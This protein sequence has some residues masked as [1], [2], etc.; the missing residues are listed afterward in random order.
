MGDPHLVHNIRA[1]REP[2]RCDVLICNRIPRSLKSRRPWSGKVSAH[3]MEKTTEQGR[4]Q[5]PMEWMEWIDAGYMRIYFWILGTVKENENKDG[6]NMYIVYLYLYIH[7]IDL[8][9]HLFHIIQHGNRL[10]CIE[11]LCAYTNIWFLQVSHCLLAT[12]CHLLRLHR[13]A[14]PIH[15][16]CWFLFHGSFSVHL[17]ALGLMHCFGLSTRWPKM[18]LGVPWLGPAQGTE[19]RGRVAFRNH[20]LTVECWE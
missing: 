17:L 15:L 3:E 16:G 7:I 12:S 18:A 5:Q 4:W 11:I 13:E 19:L 14:C 1:N 10:Y 20:G 6:L 8:F 2:R 9:I